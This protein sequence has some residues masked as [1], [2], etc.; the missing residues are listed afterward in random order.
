MPEYLV[1]YVNENRVVMHANPRPDGRSYDGQLNVLSRDTLCAATI[2]RLEV[3]TAGLGYPNSVFEG[4]SIH[5]AR[6]YL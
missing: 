3:E 4:A 6:K 2:V 5:P 1:V